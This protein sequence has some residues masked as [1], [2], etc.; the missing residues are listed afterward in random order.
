MRFKAFLLE[1]G[2][3]LAW[4]IALTATLGSLYFSEVMGYIPCNLCWYQ[5]IFMYPMVILLGVATVKKDYGIVKYALPTLLIG[6]AISIYHNL[7]E[8]TD[9]FEGGKRAC[10]LV[11]CDAE[12]INWFGFITIPFLSLTAYVLVIL[13]LAGVARAAR[14]SQ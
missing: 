3:A 7:M 10:G 11:P 14:S 8:K 12:Y 9:W 5:R 13:L 2:L 4:A 6:L 1:Q